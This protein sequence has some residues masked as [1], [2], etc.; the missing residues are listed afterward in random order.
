MTADVGV[1][2]FKSMKGKLYFDTSLIIL[3]I[4]RVI[5]SALIFAIHY[6]LHLHVHYYT[7]PQ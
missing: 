4:I 1:S 2:G 6:N 7:E 3:T 5:K